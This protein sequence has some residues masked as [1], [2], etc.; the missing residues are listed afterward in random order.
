MEIRF[1]FGFPYCKSKIS[2]YGIRGDIIPDFKKKSIVCL[3]DSHTYGFIKNRKTWPSYFQKNIGE[4]YQVLNMGRI[5][6]GIYLNIKWFHHFTPTLN[7]SHCIIQVPYF[8]V[9]PY[10]R[11]Q[12]FNKNI[13]HV[14]GHSAC[15]LYFSG[16]ISEDEFMSTCDSMM[17]I[18]KAQLFKFTSE[19]KSKNII[20]VILIFRS[21]EDYWKDNLIDKC[22]YYYN[23][24]I[25]DFK[26]K[27]IEC[28]SKDD[29]SVEEFGKKKMLMKDN[30]HANK[31]GNAYIAK[32]LGNLECF[33]K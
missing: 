7:V 23:S 13:Y 18:N 27:D 14:N 2:D 1:T 33:K 21:F 6:Y 9:T 24:L 8:F 29:L 12:P 17:E 4:E 25:D 22:Q 30:L 10:L 19:L 15:G 20:P 26:K 5:G 31:R 32:R 3:G 28:C 16:K 11:T